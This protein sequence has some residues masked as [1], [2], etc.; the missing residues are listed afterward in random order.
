MGGGFESTSN[1]TNCQF[2]FCGIGNI[3]AVSKAHASMREMAF[4]PEAFDNMVT[5]SNGVSE[6][7]Y[8]DM[9]SLILKAANAVVRAITVG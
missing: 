5:Y 2:A 1:Y 9:I 6:T 3:H 8:Y 4:T 7:G